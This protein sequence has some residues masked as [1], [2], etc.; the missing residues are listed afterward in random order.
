MHNPRIQDIII[1]EV[2]VQQVKDNLQIYEQVKDNLQI[3][4]SF[5]KTF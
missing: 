1:L 4:G 2:T 3:M 5:G